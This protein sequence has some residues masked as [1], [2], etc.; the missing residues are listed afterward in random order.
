MFNVSAQDSGKLK[1]TSPPGGGQSQ[2]LRDDS[3]AREGGRRWLN[4]PVKQR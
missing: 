1:R 4:G 3:M 2:A